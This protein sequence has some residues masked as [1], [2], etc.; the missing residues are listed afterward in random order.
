MPSP[1]GRRVTVTS[2]RTNAALQRRRRPSQEIDDQTAVGD[3]YMRS[4][5]R[6]QLRLALLVLGVLGVTIGALPATFAL[7]PEVRSLDVAGVPLA[8]V[9]LGAVVYPVLVALGWFFVRHAEATEDD[10][11]DLVERE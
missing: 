9:V 5:I 8:W 3:A 6:S 10:F 1:A 11:A 4:L 2:P 7:L